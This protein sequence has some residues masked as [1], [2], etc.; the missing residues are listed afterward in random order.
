MMVHSF[1]HFWG[2]TNLT[3]RKPPVMDIANYTTFMVVRHPFERILSA[4]YNIKGFKKF[5]PGPDS[6]IRE[7]ISKVSTL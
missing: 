3:G 5:E 6:H 1:G 2:K 7:H 4:F